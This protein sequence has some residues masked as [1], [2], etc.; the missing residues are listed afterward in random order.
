MRVR[1]VHSLTP[2]SSCMLPANTAVPG[3]LALEGS[4]AW[5]AAAGLLA[6]TSAG[7]AAKCRRPAAGK[8]RGGRLRR[9]PAL[10]PVHTLPHPCWAGSSG[11]TGLRGLRS[12]RSASGSQ[13]SGPT[14]PSQPAPSGG[15]GARVPTAFW[16]NVAPGLPTTNDEP[17]SQKVQMSKS[18]PRVLFETSRRDPR[19]DYKV[20]SRN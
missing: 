11:Q 15:E 14:A 12:Q 10:R 7:S 9:S 5:S 6:G 4:E 3:V 20:L 8:H 13:A 16:V 17:Q 18:V 1:P 2:A 19:N